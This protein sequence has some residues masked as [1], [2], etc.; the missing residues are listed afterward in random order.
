MQ[1][2]SLILFY[3]LGI[4]VFGILA[5]GCLGWWGVKLAWQSLFWLKMGYW[6]PFSIEA[7]LLETGV[8]IPSTPRFLGVQRI[9]DA[10]LLWPGAVL[11]L[12]IAFLCAGLAQGCIQAGESLERRTEDAQKISD[13]IANEYTANVFSNETETSIDQ[14]LVR[15]LEKLRHKL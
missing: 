2:R 9:I 1:E 4:V 3:S 12:T 8:G 5:F 14:I 11:Q 6:E 7:L 10:V 15:E 13:D